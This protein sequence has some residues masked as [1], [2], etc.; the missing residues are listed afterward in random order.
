M[1]Y[2]VYLT[3]VFTDGIFS[4]AKVAVAILNGAGRETL[5][6]N[7]A[8]EISLPVT[9]Y[10]LPRDDDFLVRFFTLDGEVAQADQ[11]ALA[12]AHV[13]REAGLWPFKQAVSLLSRSGRLEIRFMAAS[14][15]FGLSLDAC[16]SEKLEAAGPLI[17]ALGLRAEE[18]ISVEKS[19]LL[20]MVYCRRLESLEKAD[21]REEL[22]PRLKNFSGLIVS[23]P[24]GSFEGQG[25]ET[26]A[27]YR[28]MPKSGDK[29]F[30]DTGVMD[31]GFHG[32][33]ATFWGRHLA[34]DQLKAR[35]YSARDG[36]LTATLSPSSGQVVI[37]GR[38]KTI[39]TSSPVADELKEPQT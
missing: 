39:L 27:F 10:V 3:N 36:A 33:A 9:A 26:R 25:Y 12:S 20:A 6:K 4:G 35:P 5:L 7:L 2:K 13:L 37:G 1:I 18:V 29:I 30:F 8:V 31:L 21:F 28:E 32:P 24:S 34:V 15:E 23:A 11:A 16:R 17:S 14:G 38:V 22:W 19:G